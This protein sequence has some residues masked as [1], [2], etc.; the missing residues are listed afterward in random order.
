MSVVTLANKEKRSKQNKTAVKGRK[1]SKKTQNTFEKET[2]KIFLKK[3]FSKKAIK[4]SALN[5]LYYRKWF[6]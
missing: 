6:L 1:V 4:L 5:L 2:Q 3:A